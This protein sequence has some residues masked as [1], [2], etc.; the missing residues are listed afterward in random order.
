[1][2][3]ERDLFSLK[4]RDAIK[5]A[6]IQKLTRGGLTSASTLSEE[7]ELRVDKRK[8]KLSDKVFGLSLESDDQERMV[9]EC[10]GRP[11][12]LPK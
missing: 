6:V 3:L 8:K 12:Y 10:R 5:L 2:E 4:D 9:T 7:Q 1:M 11:C